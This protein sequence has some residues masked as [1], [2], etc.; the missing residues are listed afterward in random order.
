MDNEK[1]NGLIVGNSNKEEGLLGDT[2]TRA[3]STMY[4]EK[5]KKGSLR[6]SVLCLVCLSI[7]TS[8][9]S[10]PYTMK[11]NGV[12]LCL[13]LFFIAW[14]ATSWTMGL[15]GDVAIKEDTFDYTDLVV[16]YYGEQMGVITE[17]VMLINN[18][19]GIICMN[20]ISKE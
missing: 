19:A 3:R 18:L 9:L 1:D 2:L 8:V 14:Y 13:I 11:A 10:M 12:I 20:I 6:A 15:L 17:I 5:I 16:K 7:S 4:L